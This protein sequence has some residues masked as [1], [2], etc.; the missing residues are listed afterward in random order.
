MNGDCAGTAKHHM[1]AARGGV[2]VK[3]H[4]L[5][6]TTTSRSAFPRKRV[7]LMKKKLFTVLITGALAISMAVLCHF[8]A[9]HASAASYIY[10]PI[11][12]I[13]ESSNYIGEIFY[14]IADEDPGL[15]DDRVPI[16]TG[17]G[18]TAELVLNPKNGAEGL[19]VISDAAFPGP[20][21]YHGQENT[22]DT[23]WSDIDTSSITF[24]KPGEYVWKL[25]PKTITYPAGVADAP[26][27]PYSEDIYLHVYVT[28]NNGQLETY[29]SYMSYSV[30][31]AS[32]PGE[33]IEG[34][35]FTYN[36]KSIHLSK[37]VTGSAGNKSK[38]F[39]FTV[40]LTGCNP[41][42]VIDS[43]T[44]TADGTWS[45]NYGITHNGSFTIEGIPV[46]AGYTITEI[47]ADDYKTSFSVPQN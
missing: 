13:T 27:C 4:A 15:E 7:S 21:I 18:Y 31:T 29:G 32:Q 6:P 44:V 16:M 42:T 10:E 14:H 1:T 46:G 34:P 9:M 2:S 43:V 33:K 39:T 38:T 37:K 25:T 8:S 28:D 40:N 23:T 3:L 41:G 5:P 35:S 20:G 11:T 36:T 19:P 24:T 12:G 45:K 22:P 47:D 30:D 17:L 26:E